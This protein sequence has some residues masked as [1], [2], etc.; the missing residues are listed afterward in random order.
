MPIIS[1]PAEIWEMIFR[2]LPTRTLI[3]SSGSCS[4][5]RS[6]G[7]ALIK[8]RVCRF[9]IYQLY[10]SQDEIRNRPN[11]DK[12]MTV[13]I[14][15]THVP[16]IDLKSLKWYAASVLFR[17][18]HHLFMSPKCRT[19]EVKSTR[20]QIVPGQV[21]LEVYRWEKNECVIEKECFYKF[22]RVPRLFL[23]LLQ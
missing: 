4:A 5:A 6:A 14:L 11:V 9:T 17:P 1:I 23:T 18:P 21:F 15:Q 8:K 19:V 3:V 13:T 10:G 12:K 20:P 2:G 16:D 7:L 22:R